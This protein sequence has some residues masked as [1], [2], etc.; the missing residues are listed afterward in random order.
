MVVVVSG[1]AGR[2]RMI[3]RRTFRV[4]GFQCEVSFDP[5]PVRKGTVRVGKASRLAVAWLPDV[6]RRGQLSA[7][8]L[9][10]YQKH[11]NAF[12]DDVTKQT[13]LRIWIHDL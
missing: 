6:P 1:A 7:A 4:G 3:M 10:E 8:D 9:A 2:K 13:G 11:R 5:R 12:L